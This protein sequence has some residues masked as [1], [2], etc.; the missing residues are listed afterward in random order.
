M[1]AEQKQALSACIKQALS[2][3]EPQSMPSQDMR[4]TILGAINTLCVRGYIFRSNVIDLFS[5]TLANEKYV[6]SRFEISRRRESLS[7]SHH[8]E[9]AALEPKQQDDWLDK[10]EAVH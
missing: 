5:Q 4:S 2:A 10:A 8:S 6:S 1:I 3:E 9:V 7:F